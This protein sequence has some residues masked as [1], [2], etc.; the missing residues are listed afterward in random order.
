MVSAGERQSGQGITPSQSF[1]IIN[2]IIA[3]YYAYDLVH[4][5][6]LFSRVFAAKTAKKIM[7]A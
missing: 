5:S 1:G 3:G 2:S 7:T 4:A 6:R